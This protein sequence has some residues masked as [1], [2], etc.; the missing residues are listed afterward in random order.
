MEKLNIK[1][2]VY[3]WIAQ[4]NGRAMPSRKITADQSF[5]LKY[6]L[7]KSLVSRPVSSG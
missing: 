2:Y 5:V 7:I 6:I 4:K 3:I 1:I